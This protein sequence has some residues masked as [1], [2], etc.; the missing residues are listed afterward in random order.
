MPRGSRKRKTPV[1]CTTA[2]PGPVTHTIGSYNMS[3]ASDLGAA[4]GS[5]RH[6]ITHGWA[7][8]GQT[9]RVLWE[10]ALELLVHFW[11][12]EFRPSA[13]GMQELNDASIVRRSNPSA[14]VGGWQAIVRRLQ[15]S[16][17][18]GFSYAI[19]HATMKF[20]SPVV[21][22]VWDT[23][24]LGAEVFRYVCDLQHDRVA[25]HSLASAAPGDR[26]PNAAGRPALFVFTKKGYILVNVHAPNDHV[27][28]VYNNLQ[29]TRD[30][31]SMAFERALEQFSANITHNIKGCFGWTLNPSKVLV[32]GDFND[33]GHSLKAPLELR[34]PGGTV[35][36]VKTDGS[37]VLSCC[38][39]FNS[40]CPDGAH[41]DGFPYFD[42]LGDATEPR[43]QAGGY[44]SK[45]HECWVLDS[46]EDGE[47]LNQGP[48]R[49]INAKYPGRGS[50]SSYRFT[51]D[52][53]MGS[54]PLGEAI[55]YRPIEF[56]HEDGFS[57]ESDH[58]MVVGSFLSE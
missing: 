23:R 10:N 40:A 9:G 43:R 15:A 3:F 32:M 28:S 48:A 11:E 31:L 20:G 34:S 13:M 51:G 50:L 57:L 33:P 56:Q 24:R 1:G 58:E 30:S 29:K 47:L 36:S 22:T 35:V 12:S 38:Y 52:Y 8:A 17:R 4:I 26:M 54:I 37:P 14:T 39:N 21:M 25:Q 53:V 45:G 46:K 42:A 41:P 44:V 55:I 27:D 49:P 2:A 16:G 18:R 6:F 19:G 7:R 5:E